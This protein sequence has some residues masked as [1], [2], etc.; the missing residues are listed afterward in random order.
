MSLIV[1]SMSLRF[2]WVLEVVIFSSLQYGAKN[3]V[4]A[5]RA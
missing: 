3:T 2:Q 4:L 5:T 1:D